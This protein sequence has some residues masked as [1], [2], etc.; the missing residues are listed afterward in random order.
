MGSPRGEKTICLP[1]ESEEE[2][3]ACMRSPKRFRG[4]LVELH[5][6]FPELFPQR[7]GEG[8]SLDDRRVSEKQQLM[9]RR[10]ELQA[11]RQKFSIRPS[12]VLSYMTAT[13]DDVEK[14]M[15]LRHWN[16]P[17]DGLS[18]V[19]GRSPMF[20]Y[21]A[22]RALGRAS[23]VGSTVKAP[24]RLPKHLVGDEKHSKLL[25][26]KV[27]VPTVVGSGC[28]LGATLCESA[29]AKS[30]LA[31]Y[32]EFAQEARELCPTYA[33]ETVCTDGWEATQNAFKTLFKGICIIL[34]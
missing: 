28:I 26:E 6:K 18:Y 7:F 22:E 27:F 2:Y 13:T 24:E 14:A 20:W 16:V 34:C 1:F 15:Y 23:I 21:R 29:D 33:P 10:V 3:T 31:A 8:F 4:K 17:Y 5:G 25:G 19:F 30:L 9:I 32:G 11:T 12:F